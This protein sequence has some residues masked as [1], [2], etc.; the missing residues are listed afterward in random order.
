MDLNFKNFNPRN[1]FNLENL[2]TKKQKVVEHSHYFQCAFKSNPK[3]SIVV[4]LGF[5]LTLFY[6]FF[7]SAPLNF[8]T[9]SVVEVQKGGTT[10]EIAQVLDET[11]TIKSSFLFEVAI[12]VLRGNQGAM[13][14]TYFFEEKKNLFSIVYRMIKGK[15]GLTPTKITLF[16]GESVDEMAEKFDS[17]KFPYFDK[18]EF[19][20]IARE[21]KLEGY[22]FPDTY[23]F[24]PIVT[25]EDIIRTMK[26]NFEKKI[27]GVQEKIDL[28]NEGR[29]EKL[30]L[31]EI[32]T[33]ASLIEEEARRFETMKMVSGILW[34]RIDIGM[35]LQVDAVFP[36]II[37]KNTFQVTY[38][39]LKIDSP[40]NTYLYPG[41]P[42]GPI[43]NPGLR[44]ITATIEPTAS[45]YL[46]YLTGWDGNMYYAETHDGHVFNRNTYLKK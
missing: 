13:Y 18:Q 24:L 39:D 34:N 41:L 22:L 5:F 32:L 19:K 17:E 26:N 15:Y 25:A 46:F 27:S 3:T 40:Y 6:F 1:L 9:G 8:P 42:P 37:G 28:F 16:E 21:Q 23:L 30:T 7:I 36:Y 4:L 10:K 33:M 20:K 38:D 35:A 29:E 45:D 44:A 12:R 2:K 14:G 31:H 43:T 11:D